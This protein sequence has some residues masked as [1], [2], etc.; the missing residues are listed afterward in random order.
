MME[1]N[2]IF[3]SK[4]TL[5]PRMLNMWSIKSWQ[6]PFEFV[7]KFIFICRCLKFSMQYLP[8]SDWFY[9]FAFCLLVSLLN[10][11]EETTALLKEF[12]KF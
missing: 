10:C 9:K 7:S 6:V 12:R 5:N 11:I 8:T 4:E 1:L 3:A 2:T